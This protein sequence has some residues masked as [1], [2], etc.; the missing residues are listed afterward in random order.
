[1]PENVL[2]VTA[3]RVETQAVLEV[4]LEATGQAPSVHP[5]RDRLYYDLGKINDTR[6]FMLECEMGSGGLGGSQESVRKGIQAISPLAVIMVGIAFGMDARKQSIGDILVSQQLLLYEYQRVGTDR[7]GMPNLVSRGDK[8][9]ASMWLI[10]RFR[11][12]D[13]LRQ[14]ESETKVS[15]GLILS[16]EKLVDNCDFR[17]KLRDLAP[18]AIG[19]EM[20]GTG[21][22]VSC[23]DEQ[24]PW[25]VVKAI[26]DWADGHKARNKGKNQRLAAG[27]AAD[28]VLRMLQLAPFKG[29]DVPAALPEPIPKADPERFSVMVA[30]LEHDEKCYYR[31]LI[32]EA[33]KEYRRSTSPCTRPNHLLRRAGARSNGSEGTQKCSHVSG[34]ERRLSAHL[35][36]SSWTR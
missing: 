21:L 32:L 23:Q 10:N 14:D 22:Y 31:R 17:D 4:F 16:G 5:I 12:V 24:V 6:V 2:I 8:P 20:E 18:E 33:L 35:G 30:H 28:L 15:F 13:S 1:M 3:T 11:A 19:G 34:S 9:H 7:E 25:I 36:D 26:C 29:I 27:K